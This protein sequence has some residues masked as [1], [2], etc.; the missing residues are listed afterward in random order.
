MSKYWEILKIAYKREKFL[1]VSNVA[2]MTITFLVLGFFLSTAVGMQ[3]AIKALEEQ[4]QVT[5][6]FKDDYPET[7]ILALQ[8]RLQKDERVLNVRYISKEEAFEIFTDIN[9]D[10]PILL[11]AISKDI[12]P[13]S[14][15]VRA[16][17]LASLAD[18]ATELEGIDGVEDVKFF[19]DIVDRFRYWANVIYIVGGSLVLVFLGLSFAIIMA[20]LRLTINAKGDE[21]EIMKLVGA[22]D[23]Y[24][25]NPFLFQGAFFGLLSSGLAS[26]ILVLLFTSVQFL[27]LFGASTTVVLLPGVKVVTWLFLIILVV[28]LLLFG[29]G[30]GY[31][32]SRTAIKKY[33][34]Y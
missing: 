8:Q 10:E 11:E 3:T 13:A 21:I 14:L 9:K 12:L 2:V 31:L 25:K 7:E 27:G 24:V 19:K 5:L 34:K 26:F 28:L 16:E 18:L 15:E 30:L 32:G 20:T 4:A 1:V 22:S 6:F 23:A 29:G 33:L 17:R